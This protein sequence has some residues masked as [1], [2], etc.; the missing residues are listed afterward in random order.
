MNSWQ[1]PIEII[2]TPLGPASLA[3]LIATLFL[4]ANLSRRLGA[5]TKMAPYYKWFYV[6][7][8]FITAAFG[9]S[10][11]RSAAFLSCHSEQNFLTTP[12]FGLLF[13]HIPLL[14]GTV[15]SLIAAWRYWAWLLVGER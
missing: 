13:Y 15:A 11:L 14:L 2:T 1:V 12:A 6:G 7:M 5:V 8:A 9:V 3:A 10:V 4:Y